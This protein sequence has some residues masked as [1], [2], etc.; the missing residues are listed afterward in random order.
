MLGVG[1]L[2]SYEVRRRRP[3]IAVRTAIGCTSRQ[4]VWLFLRDAG[5]PLAM[6]ILIGGSLAWSLASYLQPL[7]HGVRAREPITF[8]LA[9]FTLLASSV[10]PDRCS[11]EGVQVQ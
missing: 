7:L 11:G 3:E 2:T 10:S 9:G 8:V 4:I 6:G 5:I 1:S